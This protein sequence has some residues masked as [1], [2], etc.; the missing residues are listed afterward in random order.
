MMQLS[1]DESRILG[2][3]IEKAQTTP[4][5]YPMTL[6][7]LVSG[8]NQKSNRHPVLTLTEDAVITA[9]DGL[10][11]KN[12]V[13]E[14]ML[15]GSRVQK[16]RHVAREGLGLSTNELVVLAELL[17]RGPQT[18][19]EIRGRASRMHPI[20][21]LEITQNILEHLMGKDPAF[22]QTI[23]P[24]P[25]SRSA[26]F[27]QCLGPNP[28]EAMSAPVEAPPSSAAAPAAAASES[29]LERRLATLEQEVAQIKAV[30]DQLT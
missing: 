21:S 7:A 29:D 24:A 19:G 11:T 15:S 2:V 13:H 22:V 28:R 27:A 5:Q 9:L 6:N 18:L 10:R 16:Y 25:G 8:A 26:R 3:L 4:G 12:L 17:L 1:R 30:L 14:V 23:A 20:E